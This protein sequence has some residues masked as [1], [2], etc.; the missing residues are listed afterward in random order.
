MAKAKSTTTN[1]SGNGRKIDEKLYRL[2]NNAMTGRQELF[3]QFFDP[4][5][6]I[7]DECGYPKNLEGISAQEYQDLY[8]REAIAARVVEVLPR[9]SWQ[10]QPT[11]YETEDAND[12]TAFEEGWDNLS[13]SLR[14]ENSYYGEE[15][16]SPVWEYLQR[17]DELSGIGY[18]GVLLL[19]FDD[20]YPPSVPMGGA[21]PVNK[22][23]AEKPGPTCNI[24]LPKNGQKVNLV[25]SE[26]EMFGT[27][28][29]YGGSTADPSTVSP[30]KDGTRLLFLRAFPQSLVQVVQ[31]E[32]NRSSPRYGQP[33]RYAITLSDPRESFGGI[34][35]PMSTLYVHWTRI[36]HVA[37][38]RGYSEIFGRPRMRPVLY[39][40]LDLQKLYSGSAE[41]YW[42]GAFPGLSLETH[43]QLGGDVELDT[44]GLRDMME[45]YMNGLQRYLS[46]MGM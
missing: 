17:V 12:V 30:R 5:R 6:D 45:N 2:I 41:M 38:N 40:L 14:G 8:N 4:R 26:K 7:T 31:Y 28:A 18:F 9:E 29:Q 42:R 34:G 37:D 35:M 24:I 22:R 11:V 32:S 21:M 13:R 1:G 19:G 10:V 33:I 46:L 44:G 43:P 20:G 27:D 25:P 16:S 15:D 23:Q 3:R 39:R 36:L